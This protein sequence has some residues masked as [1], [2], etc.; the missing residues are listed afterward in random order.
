MSFFD[1]KEDVMDIQ[2]TS[3]GKRLLSEGKFKPVYYSFEDSEVIYDYSFAN[4]TE[5]QNNIHDRIKDNIRT[6]TQAIF[7]GVETNVFKT[8]KMI[9]AGEEVAEM[10]DTAYNFSLSLGN[11][12]L[13]KEYAPSWKVKYLHGE[14]TSSV[15]FITGS[16]T[17]L[18]IP[19]LSSSIEYQT[20]VGMTDPE[21]DEREKLDEG[22][23]KIYPDGSY[24]DVKDD[25]VLLEIG[26]ENVP[27][28]R[29]NFDI[30]VYQYKENASSKI[31]GSWMELIPLYFAK[32]QESATIEEKS[33]QSGLS[34]NTSYVDY[35]LDIL[36]DQEIDDSI[37][38][39]YVGRQNKKGVFADDLNNTCSIKKKEKD[40][41]LTG[42]EDVDEECE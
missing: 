4:V 36:T 41:Y 25:F 22:I 35:F 26:E 1:K 29:E 23:E 8:N 12:E 42:I 20:F 5:T 38:C 18:R 6:K 3:H 17:L 9:R 28:S 19:R 14:L 21:I 10:E 15:Y 11:S 7:D 37:L 13:A 16:H 34:I 32:K 27:F 2:L 31:S 39:E 24:I 33:L 30:E 40:I